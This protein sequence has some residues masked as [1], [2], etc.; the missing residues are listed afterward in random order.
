MP[1]G[2]D[3]LCRAGSGAT[4]EPPPKRGKER[5]PATAPR[6]QTALVAVRETK[7]DGAPDLR[8]VLDAVHA[9]VDLL[10]EG[11]GSPRRAAVIA[12]VHRA[13]VK[14]VTESGLE[15]Q[16]ILDKAG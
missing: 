15:V 6:A 13:G 11:R 4:Y 1:H 12:A 14:S 2:H 3:T 7:E 8:A 5:T 10:N 9:R 16:R